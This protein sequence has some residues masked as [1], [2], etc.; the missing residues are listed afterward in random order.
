M[1]LGTLVPS[2]FGNILV[3]KGMN[4]TEERLVR[5]G[6]GNKKY[7]GIVRVGHGNKMVF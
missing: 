1:S 5:A 3:G 2:L 4:R 7:R 6:Y